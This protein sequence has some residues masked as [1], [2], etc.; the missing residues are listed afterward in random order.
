[1]PVGVYNKTKEHK[2][3]LSEA[4]KGK[5]SPLR[6]RKMSEEFKKKMSV[7][8]LGNANGK[9]NKGKIRTELT[10]QKM[11]KALPR[12]EK[13]FFWKKKSTYFNTHN[14]IIRLQLHCCK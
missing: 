2:Q 10:R 14:W 13:H 3:K 6:G 1:M 5:P 11:K 12:G 7:S 8:M 9:G 4:L